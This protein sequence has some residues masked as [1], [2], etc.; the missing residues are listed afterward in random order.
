MVFVYSEKCKKMKPVKRTVA[1]ILSEL[2]ILVA[3]PSL[4]CAAQLH[5]CTAANLDRVSSA[6]SCQMV[7]VVESLFLFLLF[8]YSPLLGTQVVVHNKPQSMHRPLCYENIG[9]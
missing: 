1:N 6:V 8:V 7:K 9:N 3:A 5:S 4:V 2:F